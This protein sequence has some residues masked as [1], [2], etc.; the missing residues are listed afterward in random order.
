MISNLFLVV[1]FPLFC[2][3]A[4]TATLPYGLRWTLLL[5]YTTT[6]SS[7]IFMGVVAVVI[8]FNNSVDSSLL[9]IVNGVAATSACVGRMVAPVTAGSIFSWSLSKIGYL[10]FPFNQYFVF[11]VFSV[12][13]IIMAVISCFLPE[14]MNLKVTERNNGSE[15]K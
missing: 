2:V 13:A 9:G 10:G 6:M 3:V 14:H 1:L 11:L 7:F 12:L 4:N 8:M 5:V 15:E